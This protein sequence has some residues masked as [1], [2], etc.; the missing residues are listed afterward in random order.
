MNQQKVVYVLDDDGDAR[1]SLASV[2]QSLGYPAV[3]FE[4][5]ESFLE[6]FDPGLRGC[7]VADVRMGGISG[8]D[9]VH[10][11]QDK[12]LNLPVVVV[13]GY[14]DVR[15]AVRAMQAGATTFLEKVG[16]PGEIAEAIQQ[17]MEQEET[18]FH[19]ISERDGYRS[20]I[21][22]LSTDER[23]VLLRVLEGKPNKVIKKELDI[24]LRTAEL[25]RANVMRKMGARSLAELVRM[26]LVAGVSPSEEM[27]A[28]SSSNS[29]SIV[30]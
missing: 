20:R 1:I 14:A 6:Q 27:Q 12:D 21:E 5:A 24:G 18:R 30:S 15:L 3:E 16:R 17:A 25:R 2:V 7:V 11:L 13:T 22:S 4:S 9:L 8:V 23:D 29:D 28:S 26:T 10:R 19:L